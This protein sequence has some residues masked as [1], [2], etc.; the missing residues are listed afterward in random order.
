MANFQ[1]LRINIPR[2]ESNL[3]SFD[4]DIEGVLDDY[5]QS[6]IDSYVVSASELK[7]YDFY[8]I[9]A[10][11]VAL[12]YN[13]HSNSIRNLFGYHIPNENICYTIQKM[14]IRYI[15]D[16]IDLN[17]YFKPTLS[18]EKTKEIL[19]I[20]QILGFVRKI[21]KDKII[22]TKNG[23]IM[24]QIDRKAISFGKVIFRRSSFKKV[25]RKRIK[26]K[27]KIKKKKKKRKK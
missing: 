5:N 13:V 25:K 22:F 24:Y 14:G 17:E 10:S 20:M 27:R 19:S 21:E 1:P 2:Q 7:E 18:K 9:N 12:G 6:I 3:D 8:I 23:R 11:L 16:K 4:F 26:K 15:F